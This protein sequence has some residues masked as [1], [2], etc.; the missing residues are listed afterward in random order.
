M[1][2]TA[3]VDDNHSELGDLRHS[4][5]A[6]DPS[7]LRAVFF[8]NQVTFRYA[9]S[10]PGSNS[11]EEWKSEVKLQNGRVCNA[12]FSS[13]RALVFHQ[14]H[15]RS[16]NSIHPIAG[17]VATNMCPNCK[18]THSS[19]HVA[20]A[21]A[22]QGCVINLTRSRKSTAGLCLLWLDMRLYSGASGPSGCSSSPP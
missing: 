2:S 4:F 13:R 7:I 12:T 10:S 1:L 11:S 22:F 17:A 5:L 18:T 16:H 19:K 20:E 9:S 8:H 21:S 6:I 3:H 15:P 14:L